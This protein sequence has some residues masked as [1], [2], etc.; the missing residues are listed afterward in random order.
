MMLHFPVSE[1][2]LDDLNRFIN[3]NYHLNFPNSLLIAQA[4]CI[5]CPG[6]GK[7]FGLTAINNAVEYI[8]KYGL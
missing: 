8:I 5:K 3:E 7:E 1:Y 2:V 6:Y 4:F